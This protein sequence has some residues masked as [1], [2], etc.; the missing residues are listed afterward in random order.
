MEGSD[1]LA[2]NICLDRKLI[3]SIV[4]R[5]RLALD[6]K[7][8]PKTRFVLF[9]KVTVVDLPFEAERWQ[10]IKCRRI[11]NSIYSSFLLMIVANNSENSSFSNARINV[12]KKLKHTRNQ[13]AIGRLIQI[14]EDYV[15]NDLTS[16][17]L[18]LTSLWFSN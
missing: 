16:T 2:G 9:R 7:K 1:C 6:Y 3:C 13:S 5:R 17:K 18:F 4:L 10:I 12:R 14:R 15:P 8:S 11:P